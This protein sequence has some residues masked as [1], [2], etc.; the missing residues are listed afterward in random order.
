M[1][2]GLDMRIISMYVPHTYMI[3]NTRPAV[4]SFSGEADTKQALSPSNSFLVASRSVA[5]GLYSSRYQ[6]SKKSKQLP[7]VY[8]TKTVQEANIVYGMI[9]WGFQLNQAARPLGAACRK[10]WLLLTP[11][12]GNRVTLT[13]SN[14]V[15]TSL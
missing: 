8:V 3:C 12:W 15:G 1:H 2:F 5:E 6:Q 7:Q 14:S 10:D 13:R 9:Y 11:P 4:G